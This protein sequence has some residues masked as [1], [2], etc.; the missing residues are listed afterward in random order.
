MASFVAFQKIKPKALKKIAK[1]SIDGLEK[2][3]KNNP[4]RKVCHAELWYGIQYDFK[5]SDDIA[6]IINKQLKETL[7]KDAEDDS[8]WAK[9]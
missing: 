2:W 9:R 7:K 4:K 3:F 5:P 6:V 8:L 1:E